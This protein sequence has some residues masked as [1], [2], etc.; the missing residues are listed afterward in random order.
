MKIL[1][2][3]DSHQDVK[4]VSRLLSRVDEYDKVVFCG[5]G[6]EHVW[7]YRDLYLKKFEMVRGNCDDYLAPEQ[8]TFFAGGI[9]FFVAHGHRYGVR[10]RLDMLSSIALVNDCKVALYGH[11]HVADATYTPEGVL[12]INPG[13]LCPPAESAT[14]CELTVTEGNIS[15]IFRKLSDI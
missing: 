4:A 14:F 13:H 12:C 1:V 6:I 2:F 10:S 11:S 3:S 9:K 8:I 5:D 7:E 15:Y